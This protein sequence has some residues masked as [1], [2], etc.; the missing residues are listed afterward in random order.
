MQF[1]IIVYV[2]KSVTNKTK[3]EKKTQ[4]KKKTQFYLFLCFF[5]GKAIL[6]YVNSKYDILRN[7]S[8]FLFPIR[9]ACESFTR[10]RIDS[11][12]KFIAAIKTAFTA[13][14]FRANALF[15]C[16]SFR[17]FGVR[18]AYVYFVNNQGSLIV[19]A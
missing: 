12:L 13:L 15:V 9:M 18:S 17:L 6:Q 11:V 16:L 4:I 5:N 10:I 8:V 14:F 19:N 7:G 2:C 3:R 1:I